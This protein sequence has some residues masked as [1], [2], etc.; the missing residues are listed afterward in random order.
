MN[1]APGFLAIVKDAKVRVK[2][3]SFCEMKQRLDA[4]EKFTL[5]DFHEGSEWTRGHLPRAIHLD[6]GIIERDIELAGH[7]A[8]VGDMLGVTGWWSQSLV[9]DSFS[10]AGHWSMS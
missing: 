5:V 4:G 8:G 9:A 7:E 1:R 6:K 3:L 2:E 10:E